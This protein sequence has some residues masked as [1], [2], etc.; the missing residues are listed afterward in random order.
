MDNNDKII[1]FQAKKREKQIFP[2]QSPDEKAKEL[3]MDAMNHLS[4]RANVLSSESCP[5]CGN[6]ASLSAKACPNCGYRIY[7]HFKRNQIETNWRK[8][9]ILWFLMGIISTVGQFAAFKMK[10]PSF[11]SMFQWTF[12][13]FVL[14]F[15][16]RMC[17]VIYWKEIGLISKIKIW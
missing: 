8:N 12:V 10:S 3:S 4:S 17:W 6:I 1:D 7:A 9:R 5:N 16:I 2:N 11:F 13:V 14:F 15:I